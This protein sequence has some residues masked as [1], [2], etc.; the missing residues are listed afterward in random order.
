MIRF[1]SGLINNTKSLKPTTSEKISIVVAFRNEET[2]LKKLVDALA[3]QD[4]PKNS[5]EVILVDDHSDDQGKEELRRAVELYSE[6]NWQIL[7]LPSDVYGKKSALNLG[8]T[9]AA[10]DWILLTDADCIPT[11]TWA[12]AV[13]N[14]RNSET[15]RMVCGPVRMHPFNLP[16][17]FFSMEFLSL[18]ASARG[19]CNNGTP[20]MANGANLSFHKQSVEE[21][22]T[23]IRG[24]QLSSGD[25]VFLLHA[26]IQNYGAEAVCFANTEE[27]IVTTPAPFT[28]RQFLSQRTR[29]ASKAVA[30]RNPTALF[31]AIVVLIFNAMVLAHYFIAFFSPIAALALFISLLARCALE[32]RILG[33]EAVFYGLDFLIRNYVLA[34]PL[35]PLY[36]VYS[37]IAGLG[38][39]YQWKNRRE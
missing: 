5:F 10:G 12:R 29:W 13:M 25:D 17:Q 3:I 39:K 23:S 30:Y 26:I 31:T 19:A 11:P 34:V 2:K 4:Y 14:S 8:I 9:K 1:Y 35:Y 6:I 28:I 16:G 38:N 20:F 15:C 27:A 33:K 36:I 7:S 32:I 24:Q 21:I 22:A 18:M 37:A